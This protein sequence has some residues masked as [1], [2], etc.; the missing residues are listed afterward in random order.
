M[1]KYKV[2]SSNK[3]QPPRESLNS[4]QIQ[5]RILRKD[6]FEV[7]QS[8]GSTIYQVPADKMFILLSA[9]LF[10]HT[11]NTG[12]GGDFLLYVDTTSRELIKMS[13]STPVAS[14]NS[15]QSMVIPFGSGLRFGSGTAFRLFNGSSSGTIIG[16][17][18]GY[19]LDVKDL[20]YLD[21]NLQ[22]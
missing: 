19:E 11:D 7:G 15:S 4:Q 20:E 13:C 6:I 16:G 5:P 21:K 14:A 1:A 2:F 8:H 18:Y 12:G 17:V 3:K 9:S 22:F 10:Y